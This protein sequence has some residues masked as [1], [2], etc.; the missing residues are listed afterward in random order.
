M[1]HV[2]QAGA[3][4]FRI[5]GGSVRILLVRSRKNPGV[6]VFPKG[7]L[8][9]GESHADAALREAQEE[10]GIVGT[11]VAPVGPTLTF[12]SGDE[13][14]AVKYYLVHLTADA[15]SPEGREKVWLSPDEALERLGFQNA[16]D[17]LR[18]ALRKIEGQRPA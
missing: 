1:N 2:S 14:V 13:S 12:S 7:H 5:D 16:R 8:E 3:V 6:W 10:A 15:A 17:L 18:A 11:V 9:P 4:V